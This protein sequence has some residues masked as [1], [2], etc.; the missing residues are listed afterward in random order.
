VKMLNGY[1]YASQCGGFKGGYDDLTLQK[2]A[3]LAKIEKVS[4]IVVESNFGDGMF[5]K[6]LAP[7]IAK[8]YPVSIEEV[9]HNTQKEV[10]IIDTLE[11]VMM[12]HRL[13]IDEKLIKEDYDSAPEPSYSLFYQMTRLTKD[14]GAIVHDDRLEALSMAVNYWT[15]QMDT[16]AESM[17]AQMKL[18]AFNGEIQRFIDSATGVYKSAGDRWF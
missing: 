5:S 18:E 3:N 13:I 8:T 14:R 6:L 15:E 1:L 12:Q 2:L 16:D 9:R 7:F 17:A 10:R 4:M 11:P